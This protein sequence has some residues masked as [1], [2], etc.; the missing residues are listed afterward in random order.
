VIN[1]VW[2]RKSWRPF[3]AGGPWLL[4]PELTEA[5]VMGSEAN[6]FGTLYMVVTKDGKHETIREQQVI[7][8]KIGAGKKMPN[9]GTYPEFPYKTK[10]EVFWPFLTTTIL[11]NSIFWAF[12]IRIAFTE[13]WPLSVL[14]GLFGILPIGNFTLSFADYKKAVAYIENGQDPNEEEDEE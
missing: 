5:T 6:P 4:G 12:V 13:I 10:K 1:K 8:I 2:Y 9:K 14:L 7:Y 3:D 11:M